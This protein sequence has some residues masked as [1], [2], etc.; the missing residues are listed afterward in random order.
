MTS[1]LLRL[2]ARTVLLAG[3]LG[4]LPAVAGLMVSD[5]QITTLDADHWLVRVRS[6]GPQAFDVQPPGRDP[7]KV[8]VRLHGARIGS[9][10]PVGSIPFGSVSLQTDHGDVLL[11]VNLASRSYRWKATQGPSPNLVELRVSR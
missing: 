3:I 2:A 10:A 11:R 8:V 4:P 7:S 6:S 5:V 9:L 1:R